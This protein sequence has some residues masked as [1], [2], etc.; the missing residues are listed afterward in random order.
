MQWKRAAGVVL[1]ILFAVS[2]AAG[3][4]TG[5]VSASQ[6]EDEGGAADAGG[7]GGYYYSQLPDE[8]KGFYDA[9]YQ[10]YTQGIFKTGTGDYDL[11]ANGHL[12][13]SQL[14][15]YANGNMTLLTDMGAARDAFY[16]DY[17]EIFYV[18]FSYLT[19]RVTK[20][21]SEYCAY[22]GPGRSDNYFVKGFASQEEVEAAIAEYEARIQELTA[23]ASSLPAEEGKDPETQKVT[24]IHDELIQHTSYRMEN[25][26]QE[27]NVGHIRTSYG[28][29]IKGESLCEGYARAAKAALDRLGIP[30]VLVQGG[31][32]RTSDKTEPH[33]WNY[34][35]LNGVWYGLDATADDPISPL[36]GEGG[37]DG[38]ERSDY[39][40]AGNDTMSRRHVPDGVMSEANFEF[41]YPELEGADRMFQEVA[42]T[43]GLVVTYN[44]DAVDGEVKTGVYKVSYKGMGAAKSIE[45]G[46]YILMRDAEYDPEANRW[47]YGQ[48]AYLLPD[49]YGFEDT[50]TEATIPLA[51][52]EYTEFAV[53]SEDPGDYKED[54]AEG[55]KRLTFRG[56]PLLFDASTGELFNPSGTYTPPPYVKKASPSLTSRIIIG[57]THH[58]AVDFD[59]T[60]K[61]AEGAQEAGVDVSVL[62]E[63][64][65]ALEYCKVENF[66]WDGGKTVS[67]DF[68]PSE[69]WLDEKVNYV[70]GVT[71]LVG[72]DSEK[73]PK[74]FSY[75]ASRTT[76]IC[77]FR[78]QGYYLNYFGRPQL[79]ENSD[80]SKRDF[81]EW[82]TDDNA[83]VTP[84]MLTGLT[85][86]AT[87]T[88]NAETDIINN[89]LED[90]LGGKLKSS[91]TY[92]IDLLTCNKNVLTAGTSVRLSI[93]FPKGYGPDDEGVTFK[94]YHFK[95]D[96]NGV[97]QGL[98]E[99]PLVVT[100]YGLVILCKSFS[101]F[102]VVAVEDDGTTPKTSKS[103]ILSAT[104]GGQIAGDAKEGILT[105]AQGEVR[106]LQVQADEGYVIDA[107]V[108]GGKYQEITNS[109]SMTI[110]ADYQ[111]L[112]DGDIIEA[113]FVA[114]TVRQK[115]TD[116]GETLVL[117]APL[118][119]QVS[120]KTD[121][122]SAEE[123]KGFEITSEITAPEGLDYTC[124]WYKDGEPMEGQ[125][126]KS[127]TVSAAAKQDEGDYTLAVTTRSGA[128][129]TEAWSGVCRVTVTPAPGD[130]GSQITPTPGDGGSQITPAPEE[131]EKKEEPAEK[132]P[133]L[134]KVSG[135]TIS[136]EKTDRVKLKW[137]KVTGAGGYQ[138]LRYN[139]S[140]KKF[141]KAA[142]VT[143]TAYTDK[144]R[145]GGKAY[146]Y[147]IRAYKKVNGKTYYGPLSKEVKIIVKPKA[148]AGV[149]A[150]RLTDTSV[151]ICFNPVKNATSYRI[152]E[153]KKSTG[154]QVA[155]FKVTAKKLYQYDKKTK[156]W[157]YLS[158][159]QRGK[160]GRYICELTGLSAENK[161]LKFRI[162]TTVSK[163]GYKVR[164]SVGSKLV[165][166]E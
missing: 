161:D 67:F 60:L 1:A 66:M 73:V 159:V 59:E 25:T 166:V 151:Q 132:K 108:S 16:A 112:R 45:N 42:N 94:A 164:Y 111:S 19:L 15:G 87:S 77:A 113:Q 141:V 110:K 145:T 34:V 71:G 157:K 33:M 125:M 70:F 41:R 139:A 88:S 9:M 4:F 81:Q 120:L 152:Y 7:N 57:K 28:A 93:G 122:I 27:E 22:L 100:R 53:T 68:T 83:A 85:L 11:V 54:S 142:N 75:T 12:D 18:D 131:P 123:K 95:R 102:A 121:S 147:K 165:T 46:K 106:E 10:M 89:K 138:V 78:S 51:S 109:K 140:K 80:L 133:N 63:N 79:L 156:K 107:V 114:E 146:R 118:P 136:S 137:K 162:K 44:P 6:L 74:S 86:V 52:A 72:A 119:A 58:I 38:F 92:N 23:G 96:K 160:S 35:Q 14:D 20:K 130:G 158:K 90:E 47:K 117:P 135:V 129:G 144:K 43:N 40:L 29:W 115:E 2:S 149:S 64:T 82:K 5:R 116:R 127:L 55:L 105:L 98:E 26:C 101:P 61:L 36:P 48:W 39:L 155:S 104:P 143:K 17:P 91:E 3:S 76:P 8:A 154:K 124:Q 37:V 62:E 153:Y 13:Q 103:M 21:G 148:P 50:D 24:Y 134:K 84:Q 56:D 65:T 99:V 30:C 97:I 150:V 69:M 163:K 32:R 128:A 31:F 126:G 49:V